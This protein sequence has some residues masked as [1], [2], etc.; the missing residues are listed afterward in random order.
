MA[1]NAAPVDLKGTKAPTRVAPPDAR[2]ASPWC[3]CAKASE[4]KS[5]G[6]VTR[7]ATSLRQ[8]SG[9]GRAAL[10]GRSWV[11]LQLRAPARQRA[12]PLSQPAGPAWLSAQ[13]QGWRRGWLLG[14]GGG[15]SLR[16]AGGGSAAKG[17]QRGASP[18]VTSPAWSHQRSLP[19]ALASCR[20]GQEV[21]QTTTKSVTPS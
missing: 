2:P 9:P 5:Q 12:E 20:H 13:Q 7:G 17:A 18:R 3:C 11:G 21:R 16:S 8:P 19:C 15:W 4:V 10:A 1:L 14:W 6:E